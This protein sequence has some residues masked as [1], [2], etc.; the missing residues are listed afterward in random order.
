[1]QSSLSVSKFPV[2][3]IEHWG[4]THR[5][6]LWGD[7]TLRMSDR[8]PPPKLG[9]QKDA[10]GGLGREERDGG[11]P[12][13][14]GVCWWGAGELEALLLGC[15]EGWEPGRGGSSREGAGEGLSWTHSC[16]RVGRGVQ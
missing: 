8:P 12:S 15:E 7:L 16:D 3:G 13:R 9:I 10:G 11:L 6:A 1:M 2:R 5:F 14:S 4:H